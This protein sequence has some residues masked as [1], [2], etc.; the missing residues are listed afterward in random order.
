M[1]DLRFEKPRIEKVE[2]SEDLSYGKYTVAPLQRGYG[3]T[4][5]N[6]LRRMMLSSL[7]GAAVTS[8]KIDGVQHEFS[9]IPGVKED[10]SEIV[11]NI[12]QII[13]KLH[14]DGPKT[15]RIEANGAT[16]LSLMS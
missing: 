2:Q 10:V 4:L 15:V 5:G 3:T 16:Q 14:G 1:N 9:T 8:I 7:E 6:S 12:K 11:L 13:I